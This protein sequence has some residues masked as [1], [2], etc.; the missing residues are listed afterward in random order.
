METNTDSITHKTHN[1]DGFPV[2]PCT[3]CNGT[4]KFSWNQRDGH[5]CLGCE[6]TCY[7]I[8]PKAR[9]AYSAFITAKAEAANKRPEELRV[10][11]VVIWKPASQTIRST[12]ASID[13]HA[14]GSITL[15]FASISTT[16]GFTAGVECTVETAIDFDP[17]PFVALIK[18]SK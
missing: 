17:A 15:H 18:G 12:I 5:R 1:P 4:G 3:R 9:K 6:G 13:Q 16:L 10:G 7:K 2:V 14:N 11:D 8:A